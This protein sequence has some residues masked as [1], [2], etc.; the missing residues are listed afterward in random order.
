MPSWSQAAP[1]PPAVVRG[2]VGTLGFSDRA[3]G[4]VARTAGGK[5]ASFTDRRGAASGG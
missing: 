5:T 4:A 2:V 3:A 1:A